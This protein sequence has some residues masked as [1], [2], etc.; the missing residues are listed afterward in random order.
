[1]S[2]FST[3][4]RT[5]VPLWGHATLIISSLSPKRNCSP[6]W[7]NTQNTHASRDNIFGGEFLQTQEG[8]RTHT[9]RQGGFG[10]YPDLSVQRRAHRIAQR[11][12]LFPTCREKTSFE[13]PPRGVCYRITRCDTVQTPGIPLGPGNTTVVFFAAVYTAAHATQPR[14]CACFLLRCSSYTRDAHLYNPLGASETE[15]KERYLVNKSG[16]HST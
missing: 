4:V 9:E 15:Q 1:M 8:R 16:R 14:V 6:R 2:F 12:R 13:I 11:L 3:L 7:V 10:K 5:A